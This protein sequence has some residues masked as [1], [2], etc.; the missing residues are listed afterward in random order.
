MPGNQSPA[1]P[2]GFQFL[3]ELSFQLPM[4]VLTFSS[5]SHPLKVS[6]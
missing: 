1:V 6:L 4:Q 5:G 2:I 3:S